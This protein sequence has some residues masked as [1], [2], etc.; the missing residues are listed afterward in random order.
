[1]SIN[2]VTLMGRIG[3]HPEMKQTPNG[4][5][6]TSF[7]VAVDRDYYTNSEKVTDWIDCVAWDK[8]AEFIA[9]YFTKGDMIALTGKI[10]TRKYTDKNGNNRTAYEIKVDRVS[11]CGSKEKK[12]NAL[13]SIDITVDDTPKHTL[14]GVPE[15]ELKEIPTEDDLPF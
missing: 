6:V 13:S 15:N 1:M 3:H 7:T 9:S 12:E 2:N 10:E 4:K 11:F 8:Q 14:E 5:S